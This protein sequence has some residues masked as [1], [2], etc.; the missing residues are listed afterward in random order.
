MAV[1]IYDLPPPPQ[2]PLN[3]FLHTFYRWSHDARVMFAV[4][5]LYIIAVKITNRKVRN[6]YKP[7]I[8]QT[9]SFKYLVIA[10]NVILTFFSAFVFTQML[11]LLNWNFKQRPFMEAFC[12]N[13]GL[14]AQQGVRLWTWI[15]YLSKYYELLDTAVLLAKGKQSSFLQTFHHSLSILSMWIQSSS[16]ISYGW[17][18]TTFNSFIHTIMYTY[19]TLT[20]FGFKPSWKQLLTNLQMAQFIIGNPVGLTYYVIPGCMVTSTH[21]GMKV[22]ILP[23]LD[24]NLG[25]WLRASGL[26]TAAFVS[27]LI[28]LFRDFSIKTYGLRKDMKKE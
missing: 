13:D 25:F 3:G 8:S 4:T 9:T 20:C 18:F 6:G 26:V 16:P 28:L 1:L 27:A 24:I 19:Y 21:D 2:I 5:L 7:T 23:G 10:H 15:F 22:A 17:I 14:W 12:D 11:N